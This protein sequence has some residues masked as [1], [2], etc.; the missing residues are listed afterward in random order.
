MKPI[1]ALKSARNTYICHQVNRVRLPDFEENRFVRRHITFHGRVQRVGFRIELAQMAERLELTGWV[2]NAENGEVIAEVQGFESAEPFWQ[3]MRAAE[4]ELVILDVMLPGED[5]FS[6]LKKLRNTPSL[7]KLPIIM[8]TA[9]SSE[10]DTVR[11]L[12]CG[13][14]DYIAKP[15]GIMEFLSRVRVALR[16]SAP[17]VRPDVLVFHEIQLD[18]ARHSVTVNSTPVELTYK[19]YC[20]LRLLLENTSLVV[21]R[22]T[23]L[24]VVW[25]TDISVESRT[26]DMHIRTLRKKLGDAGRYICTVRKVGYKLTDEEAEEE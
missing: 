21:T 11:G 1:E 8:V 5:G 17:E 15:F 9:K 16:R 23:I 19:E 4:P 22:E 10:L 24:Q 13:A 14:D 6:I 7:R 20:L 26:V 25:G 12:D 2:K 18:N 3:A